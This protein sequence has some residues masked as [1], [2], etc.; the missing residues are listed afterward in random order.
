MVGSSVL[1]ELSI[2]IHTFMN[3]KIF[4]SLLSLNLQFISNGWRFIFTNI[5]S[6]LIVHKTVVFRITD[7]V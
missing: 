7:T 6:F 1:Q 2:E 3:S 4:N 5:F